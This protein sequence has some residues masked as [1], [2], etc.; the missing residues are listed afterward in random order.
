MQPASHFAALALNCIQRE[1]PYQPQHVIHHAGDIQLPRT[2]HPAFYGCFDWHSAVHG[3]WLLAHVLRRFPDLPEAA[4]IR[5]AL[6]AHLTAENLQAEADYFGQ[7]NRA[8]FE[9]PYGWAW[10]LK[11]AHELLGWEDADA[12]RWQRNLQPLVRVVE[13]LYLSWLPKQTYGIRSGVHSNTAFGLAFALDHAE[14]TGRTPLRDLIHQRSLNYFVSDRDYPAA[15][16]PS[17]SDFLSPCLCEADLMRRVLPPVEFDAW[18][19]RF[20]PQLPVSLLTPVIVSDRD[21]GQLV[22]L[23]GLNL[24]R[25]WCLFKL[26]GALPADDARRPTFLSIAERHLE[27]GLSHI[28]SGN[29]AGEHWL[30]TFALL[31]LESKDRSG[32]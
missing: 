28:I 26:A 9:R 20:L 15:W 25:A 3:H 14:A 27:A 10:V 6:N 32:F 12:A 4:Q 18:L 1:Y 23:D 2:L 24:S 16:E 22:H 31:A 8:S 5:S 13:L 30:A 29:Y 21:D 7:P 19:A 11:L 17:G